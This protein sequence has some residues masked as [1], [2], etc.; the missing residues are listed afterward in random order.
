[1]IKIIQIN[2][3]EKTLGVSSLM[4]GD[5][6]IMEICLFTEIMCIKV[7]GLELREHNHPPDLT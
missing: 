5:S 4:T 7:H 1:M 2:S 6:K 3:K